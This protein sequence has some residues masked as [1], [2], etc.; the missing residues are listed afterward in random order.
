MGTFARARDE[1]C[2]PRERA[3][4]LATPRSGAQARLA[5]SASSLR[6]S[7]ASSAKRYS[8]SSSRDLV[9]TATSTP[10]TSLI[11]LATFSGICLMSSAPICDSIRSVSSSRNL[12]GRKLSQREI[13]SAFSAPAFFATSFCTSMPSTVTRS[14][15]RFPR[16]NCSSACAWMPFNAIL[17]GM[18]MHILVPSVTLNFSSLTTRFAR[19]PVSRPRLLVPTFSPQPVLLWACVFTTSFLFS[20]TTLRKKDDR[21]IL[22]SMSILHSL[23][24]ASHC[25]LETSVFS[26]T[27]GN[28]CHSARTRQ[29]TRP[30][31]TPAAQ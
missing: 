9:S 11:S 29:D 10:P 25:T 19:A 26:S 23:P 17:V 16:V 27:F 30:T 3:A 4:G 6:S 28:A 8:A 1:G 13:L 22:S 18:L 12:L 14:T 7:C 31:T 5:S 24:M 2:G 21:V 15:K 20:T